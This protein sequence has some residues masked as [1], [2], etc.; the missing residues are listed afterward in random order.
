MRADQLAAQTWDKTES[1]ADT[2]RR[3]HDGASSDAELRARANTYVSHLIFGNFP[4]ANTARRCRHS[5]D[6]QRRRLDHGGDERTPLGAR[7]L[8]Q[9]NRGP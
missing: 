3:I 7:R 9:E 5:R 1:L 4:H 2:N 8:S 6:R